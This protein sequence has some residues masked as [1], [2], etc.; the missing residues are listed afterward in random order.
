MSQQATS[1]AA[2]AVRWM[3]PPSSETLSIMRFDEGVDAARVLADREMREFAHGGFRRADEAVQ[4]ALADAVDA[5]IRHGRA[6][7]ASSSSR[8]RR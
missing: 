5:G 3:W 7:T 2:T 4:R 6:R 8:R 1:T